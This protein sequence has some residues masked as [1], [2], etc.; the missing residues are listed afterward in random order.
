M[1]PWTPLPSSSQL[2]HL[3]QGVTPGPLTRSPHAG[4]HHGRRS[5][6]STDL[7]SIE[8]WL[9]VG[10]SGWHPSEHIYRSFLSST[11]SRHQSFL[12]F[13]LTYFSSIIEA[14]IL[15]SPAISCTLCYISLSW[16][17]P[18]FGIL[19]I[20]SCTIP[21][22]ELS[23]HCSSPSFYQ[24]PN[25]PVTTLFCINKIILKSSNHHTTTIEVDCFTCTPNQHT[26]LRYLK[27]VSLIR[28]SFSLYSTV[29]KEKK[30]SLLQ[31]LWNRHRILE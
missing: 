14:V 10:G 4:L 16:T 2:H 21:C 28:E 8:R 13:D 29:S 15:F 7:S 30:F 18:R 9:Q 11:A 25:E 12:S 27:L 23:E 31:D 22:K 24:K 17:R 1:R 5:L 3:S 6:R 26:S 19:F 20:T